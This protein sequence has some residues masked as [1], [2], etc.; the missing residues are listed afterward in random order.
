MLFGGEPYR[1]DKSQRLASV[2]S[3][4]H[5]Q[6]L[7]L[8][9]SPLTRGI[10]S[11]RIARLCMRRSR[12]FGT[13]LTSERLDP[14]FR[15]SHFRS[16]I[17]HEFLRSKLQKLRNPIVNFPLKLAILSNIYHFII[18]RKSKSFVCRR[19]SMMESSIFKHDE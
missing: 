10:S 15:L 14:S 17:N 7:P 2:P 11:R 18:R 3:R 8:H 5:F 1:L 16:I 4:A 19:N 13:A 9:P 12:Y 6:F